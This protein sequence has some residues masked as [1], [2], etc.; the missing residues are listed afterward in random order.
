VLA[1][2]AAAVEVLEN[3]H[4]YVSDISA[5][6]RHSWIG[7]IPVGKAPIAV[8]VALIVPMRIVV[9]SHILPPAEKHR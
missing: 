3:V 9:V 5:L 2:V 8:T 1:T 7:I 6:S 4:L